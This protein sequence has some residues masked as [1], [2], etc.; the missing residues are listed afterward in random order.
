MFSIHINSFFHLRWYF[1]EGDISYRFLSVLVWF[2]IFPFVKIWRRGHV[3][4]DIQMSDSSIFVPFVHIY[5]IHRYVLCIMIFQMMY[6][7]CSYDYYSLLHIYVNHTLKNDWWQGYFGVCLQ[8][9]IIFCEVLLF[10]KKGCRKNFKESLGLTQAQG[11][12]PHF[13]K[14]NTFSLKRTFVC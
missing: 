12:C 11:A 10:K 2:N 8:T 1:D 4:F 9:R 14:Q 6:R 7:T 13:W 5:V 3:I